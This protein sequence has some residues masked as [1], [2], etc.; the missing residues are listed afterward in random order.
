LQKFFRKI[1]LCKNARHAQ[2]AVLRLAIF[3]SGKIAAMHRFVAAIATRACPQARPPLQKFYRKNSG[4]HRGDRTMSEPRTGHIFP[5]GKIGTP[6]QFGAWIRRRREAL[7][8]KQAELAVLVDVGPRFIAELEGG[9]P[10]C[11]IGKALAVAWA[12]G[13]RLADAAEKSE[14]QA[15]S[16]EPGPT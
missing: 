13:G 5:L 7:G 6:Q 8:L 16:P 11:Q 12:L 3:P 10:S 15:A 9:K 1:G 14:G 2:G 4:G